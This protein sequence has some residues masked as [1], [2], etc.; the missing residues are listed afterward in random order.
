MAIYFYLQL[1]TKLADIHHIGPVGETRDTAS[2]LLF[3]ASHAASSITGADL[4]VDGARANVIATM[5]TCE[6][7]H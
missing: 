2:T 3:L 7:S 1:M 6:A 5:S 4:L